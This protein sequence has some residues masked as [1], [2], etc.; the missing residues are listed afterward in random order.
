MDHDIVMKDGMFNFEDN[1][2][3]VIVDNQK[4]LK[5]LFLPSSTMADLIPPEYAWLV[6]IVIPFLIGL[7]I[8]IVVKRTMKLI[9]ALAALL[10]ILVIVGFIQLPA[11]TDI[12]RAAM[13][14]L[15]VIW[16]E[17]NP[18]INII[19]YSSVTFLIGLILGIWK[20]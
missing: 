12:A 8:G 2:K 14:Y 11:I 6:P 9:L 17:A 13:K 7:I 3:N 16:T 4:I 10:I 20:G 18:L 1:R 15:P 19:P 5:S